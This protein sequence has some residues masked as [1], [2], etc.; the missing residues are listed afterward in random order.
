MTSSSRFGKYRLIAELG[1]GG[2][3]TVY[4]AVAEG[5]EGLGFSKLIV[6]KRL[7]QEFAD[8][9]EFV[10]MLVDEARLAAR[11]NH[12]NAVQTY[13]IG[14]FEG[15][16]FIAMEHLEGQPLSR[17]DSRA[18][19]TNQPLPLN[20]R[21]SIVAD[22]LLGLHHAHELRDYDGSPLNVVHRDV[23]PQNV[24]V[25][26]DGQVK[27]VDFG[28][29]K[30]A[31]RAHETKHGIVKGKL[32]YM[33]VEQAMLWDIDRR[34]DVFS[35]G[36][37]MYEAITGKRMWSGSA[38]E[39]IKQLVKGEMPPPPSAVNPDVDPRLD[40]IC[41]KALAWKRDDRYATAEEMANEIIAYLDE[42]GERPLPRDV[43][44]VVAGMFATQRRQLSEVIESQLANLKAKPN[45][46]AFKV[47]TFALSASGAHDVLSSTRLALSQSTPRAADPVDPASISILM[48]MAG[49]E[50][51]A[52]RS[53]GR[54]RRA[55]M[56]VGV[57]IAL[58]GVSGVVAYRSGVRLPARAD[59]ETRAPAMAAIPPPRAD[60][61]DERT[62]PSP[63][64][65]P[66]AAIRSDDGPPFTAS[67]TG[68]SPRDERRPPRSV[69][70]A[71]PPREPPP[72]PP[73]ASPIATA[74]APPHAP[75][76]VRA[77]RTETSARA[78]RP[79]DE[80]DPYRK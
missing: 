8:D 29:A 69:A 26:Y 37:M 45:S 55:A 46:A 27:I 1:Q 4:L 36:A 18:Q 15:Q 47:R 54:A 71:P 51:V 52:S 3:A 76:T 13:E 64:T 7:R 48:S 34:A 31:G 25:T 43:G 39:I 60:A 77:V 22:V 70:I 65:T 38:T 35:V 74:S 79:I 68:R 42:R 16:Y 41:R 50:R 78:Q 28:I 17:I 11:L 67:F 40:A 33:A 30:A 72:A 5:P 80:D 19:R 62:P 49:G 66:A 73:S 32:V 12:P 20:Y 23:T 59:A 58:G 57:A 9:E 56:L 6:V 63:V 10:T 2:M 21:L 44:A 61:V 24:F 53:R 14:E 75:P